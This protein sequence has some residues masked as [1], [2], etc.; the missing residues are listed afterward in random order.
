M[1]QQNQCTDQVAAAQPNPNSKMKR[2]T[3]DLLLEIYISGNPVFLPRGA[4]C[5][6]LLSLIRRGYAA[7][8]RT[9]GLC[10]LTD[11]GIAKVRDL[12]SRRQTGEQVSRA[13]L[14]G[15]GE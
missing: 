3:K 1:L 12:I 5:H 11:G 8:D 4:S 6:P 14:S 15:G 13:A 2:A 10:S 9:T 7:E